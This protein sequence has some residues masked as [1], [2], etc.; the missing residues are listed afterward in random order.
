VWAHSGDEVCIFSA[1]VKDL[2]LFACLFLF[3]ISEMIWEE[4]QAKILPLL[5]SAALGFGVLRLTFV[6]QG[7]SSVECVGE[8]I[9]FDFLLLFF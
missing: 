6:K 9:L 8:C 5:E 7:Q 2:F 1:F 3:H 4:Q